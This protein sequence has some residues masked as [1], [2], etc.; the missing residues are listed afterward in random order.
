MRQQKI[1]L[2]WQRCK[3]GY[4]AV[5]FDSRKIASAIVDHDTGKIAIPENAT[6]AERE[7]I[8]AWGIRIDLS[9]DLG[10]VYRVLKPRS[11]RVSK[12]NVMN[13]RPDLFIQLANVNDERGLIDFV[14]DYGPL[15]SGAPSV[16]WHL[17]K[18][19]TMKRLIQKLAEIRVKNR[20]NKSTFIEQKTAFLNRIQK[21]KLELK[22]QVVDGELRLVLK[23]HDLLDAIRAQFLMS[24]EGLTITHCESCHN[25]MAISTQTGRSDKRFCSQAC[26]QRN[27]RRKQSRERR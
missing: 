8:S 24:I 21:P 4:E 3:D 26:K 6:D 19:Q 12:L 10:D 22:Y 23:P 16:Q 9:E 17:D 25:F 14:N 13:S 18:A 11:N 27:H 7:L 1:E 5:S 15:C 2:M 20:R